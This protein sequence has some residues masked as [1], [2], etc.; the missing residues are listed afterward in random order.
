M[1]N[2]EEKRVTVGTHMIA[3]CLLK[4]TFT[5]HNNYVWNKEKRID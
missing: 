2:V 4:N 3:D 1:E 5:K